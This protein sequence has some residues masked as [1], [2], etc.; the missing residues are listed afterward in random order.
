MA[1]KKVF[2]SL[3]MQALAVLKQPRLDPLAALPESGLEAGQASVVGGKLHITDGTSWYEQLTAENPASITALWDFHPAS[4]GVPVTLHTNAQNQLVGGLKSELL[5][6]ST[7]T[8]AAGT[9]RIS[10][11]AA[12]HGIPVY[13]ASGVL[14]VGTPAADGDAANKA[15]VDG[16]AQG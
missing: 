15:Y 9:H 12:Q 8:L 2:T 13:G 7:V 14:P 11:T 1:E 10:G 5:G 3:S 4:A 16:V 6:A